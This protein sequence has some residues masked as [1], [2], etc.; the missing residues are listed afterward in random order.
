MKMLKAILLQSVLLSILSM[1]CACPGGGGGKGGGDKR[2][3]RVSPLSTGAFH[4][5]ALTSSGGVRCWG[6]NRAGQLGEG[7]YTDSPIPVDVSGLSSGV[8]AV[9]AGDFHT[10]ALTCSGRVKCWGSSVQGELGNGTWTNS[11]VPV[12]V[13]GLASGVSAISTGG[14]HTCALTSSGG[15]K[16]WGSNEYG[17][18][19]DGTNTKS[20]VPVNVSGLASGVSTISAS[21]WF[22]CA[23]TSSGGVKCWGVNGDGVLGNGT[24]TDSN[25]PVNVSGLASGVSAISAG[26][27]TCALTSSGGVKC[28]GSNKYGNLGNG[29]NTDSNVPVNVSGLASG[30]SAISAG[31]FHTCALTSSGGVKCWG[32]NMNG[33]LGN[34]TNI[35]SNVPVNVSSLA[36]GIIAISAGSWYTCA[37]TSSG[38]VKCWGSNL[39]GR[40]GNGTKANSNVPVEVSGF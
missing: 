7:T 31:A 2:C 20:N 38:G 21:G 30:V 19:G 1:L 14:D 25:V 4:A 5:C 39:D 33:E 37:V 15:V 11:T 17:Q 3:I 27:V 12:N 22:T 28:W 6:N 23:L 36:S 29:T 24:N 32:E 18:L 35:K 8:S 9:S 10:C 16:C 40:L 13:S 26:G 34:G